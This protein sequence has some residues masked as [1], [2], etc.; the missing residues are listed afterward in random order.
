MNLFP[1]DTVQLFTATSGRIVQ[2]Q[3]EACRAET[4]LDV[5]AFPGPT[6]MQ[7]AIYLSLSQPTSCGIVDGYDQRSDNFG[8]SCTSN[9]SAVHWKIR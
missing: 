6:A 4:Q 3:S 5:P 7:I 9:P 8:K 1:D 2:L